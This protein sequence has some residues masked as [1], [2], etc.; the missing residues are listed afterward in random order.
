MR[1]HRS[2]LF[3][4]GH[5]ART[6]GPKAAAS[7]TDALIFDLEDSVPLDSK[8]E[9]RDAV[10]ETVASLRAEVPGIGLYIRLNSLDSHLT[11][12]DLAVVTVA[13][14][15]GFVLPM[16]FGRDDIVRF[17]ALVTDAE[18]RAGLPLGGL[19]F[20]PAL[21]TAQS[22]AACEAL[23]TGSP[24]VATLF[25]GTAR[26]ADVA[27]SVGFQF[28][29]E[30]LETLYLRS[31]ALLAVRAANLPFPLIGLWQDIHDLDG[32]RQFA[33]DNRRLGFRGQ[34]LIHPSH[35]PV[36]NEVYTPSQE[37]VD[38]YQGMIDAFEE[39]EKAGIAAL[40]YAGQHVDYAHIKTAREVI[41]QS[42]SLAA[43]SDGAK[44]S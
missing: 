13:G 24:R 14:L 19:E 23:I 5:R 16:L 39:A 2:L 36:V 33:I 10:A 26:D 30:G 20:I 27:R 21:E 28:T 6:W 37:E 17:D 38:F 32:C 43:R 7:G 4:P 40:D 3:V 29:P 11:G 31:K 41:E 22:Y 9:A 15:D 35:A 25:A 12:E 18:W 8:A 1:L 34:V 44:V 42:R